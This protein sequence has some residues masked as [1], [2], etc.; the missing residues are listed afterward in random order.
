VSQVISIS[1]IVL[2]IVLVFVL[3]KVPRFPLDSEDGTAE[4]NLNPV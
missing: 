2:G 3:N 1:L 4:Q